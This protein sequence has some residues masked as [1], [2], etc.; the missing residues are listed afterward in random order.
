MPCDWITI[1]A[2]AALYVNC[3]ATAILCDRLPRPITLVLKNPIALSRD[4]DEHR[5]REDAQRLS[6]EA[7][8]ARAG[9]IAEKW[10]DPISQKDSPNAG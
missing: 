10:L 5:H 7:M 6:G 4:S 9:G 3:G 8:P 1:E 2:D